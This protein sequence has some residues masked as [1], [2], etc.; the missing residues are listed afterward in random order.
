VARKI[1]GIMAAIEDTLVLK[2]RMKVLEKRKAKIEGVLAGADAPPPSTKSRRIGSEGASTSRGCTC[3]YEPST[4]LWPTMLH[5]S[6]QRIFS[7]LDSFRWSTF[8]G[9]QALSKPSNRWSDARVAYRAA[10]T[11]QWHPR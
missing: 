8:R 2:G 1:A 11:A 9:A 7:T 6:R 4:A 10:P 5:R 3:R